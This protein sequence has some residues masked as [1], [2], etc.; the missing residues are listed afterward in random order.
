MGA[1]EPSLARL[2]RLWCAEMRRRTLI[3][4]Q[5]SK[6]YLGYC[7]TTWWCTMTLAKMKLRPGP[8]PKVQ[9]LELD[10]SMGVVRCTLFHSVVGTRQ[11]KARLKAAVSTPHAAH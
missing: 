7:R 6:D 1:L 11:I 8:L 10:S 2:R 3:S 4:K 5:R 9:K